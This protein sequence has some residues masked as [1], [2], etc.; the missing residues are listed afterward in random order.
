M[1]EQIIVKSVI[2]YRIVVPGFKKDESRELGK[3]EF[4]KTLSQ[5]GVV[6]VLFRNQLEMER[7]VLA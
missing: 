7:E 5:E 2:S 3:F 4:K 1:P 6:Q